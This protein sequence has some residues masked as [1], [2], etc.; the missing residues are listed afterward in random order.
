M[1]KISVII[2][3]YNRKNFVVEAIRS[4]LQQ[5]PKNYE[6]IVVDDGSTDGTADLLRSLDLPVRIIE[7]ENGGVSKARNNGIKHAQG[8]YICLL[9]SDDL[10]LAGIL[11]QQSDYLDS[12]PEVG[13]V[14]TDQFTE[15]NK[16]QG[17]KTKFQIMQATDEQKTKFDKPNLIVPQAPIHTSATM[18]RKTVFD[19]VGL[20]NE[21]LVLH[22]D[23][24]M[25]NRISEKYLFGFIGQPLSVVRWEVDGEHLMKP[26]TR[27]LFIAEL[28][29]YMQLYE[30]RQMK[31]GTFDK[32]KSDIVESHR[33]IDR[34]EYLDSLRKSNQITEE[35]FVKQRKAIFRDRDSHQV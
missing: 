33:R 24:D 5:E 23:T 13:L 14:Y 10:W 8:E 18:I 12:H 19:E 32:K 11:Q 6:I 9:D 25:W 34:M 16:V 22:E 3:T 15:T 29:K 30:D 21:D 35:E 27:D 31:N 7:Q 26:G 17:P 20:F 2:P 4:V 28:R 1:I